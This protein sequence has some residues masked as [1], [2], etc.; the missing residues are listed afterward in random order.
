MPR[1]SLILT[2]SLAGGLTGCLD[3]TGGPST[4]PPDP[5]DPTVDGARGWLRVRTAAGIEEL[6]YVVEGGRAIHQGDIDLGAIDEVL[7]E[8]GGAVNAD[9]LWTNGVVRYWF[10]PEFAPGAC[11]GTDGDADCVCNSAGCEQARDVVREVMEELDDLLPVTISEISGSS[12]SGDYIKVFYESDPDGGWSGKSKV[13]MQGGE[14][15]LRFNTPDYDQAST[16][17]SRGTTRHEVLHAL[18]MWHE[19]ARTDRDG[20]VNVDEGCI[21]SDDLDQYEIQWDSTDVG[22]YDFRSVMHYQAGQFC[23]PWAFPTPDPD[24]DG[25]ICPPMVKWFPTEPDGSDAQTFSSGNLT[26]EDVNTLYHVY[27][28]TAGDNELGDHYGEVLAVGDFNDDGYDDIAVGAPLEDFGAGSTGA[29]Y[30]YRGTSEGPVYWHQITYLSLGIPNQIRTK[31]GAALAVGRFDD[32]DFVDLAVGAPG[33][34]N[35]VGASTASSGAVF[36]MRG[37]RNGL[38]LLRRIDQ[39]SPALFVQAN[40]DKFGAALAAGDLAGQGYDALVIGAPADRNGSNQTSGAIYAY[41]F[42]PDGS[43]VRN[44]TRFD[45]AGNATE[46]GAALAVGNLDGDGN[47]DL[48]VGIPGHGGGTGAV[49]LMAGRTPP[50]TTTPWSPMLTLKTSRVGT[51]TAGRFGASLAIGSLGLNTFHPELAIGAPGASSGRGQVLIHEVAP[52]YAF[53]QIASFTDPTP[54]IG[55]AFGTAL[56]LGHVDAGTASFQDLVIGEPLAGGGKIFFV[57]GG[58]GAL[59]GP[60][61][62]G[63]LG[64]GGDNDAGD[65]FGAAFAIGNVNGWG[66]ISDVDKKLTAERRLD[67]VVG[68]PAETPNILFFPED[69]G[70]GAFYLLLGTSSGLPGYGGIYHQETWAGL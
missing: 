17:P 68:V 41:Q 46:F 13:G 52:N 53:P 56:A 12:P 10:D 31:L 45:F 3:S 11:N 21:L 54:T 35:T 51:A 55:G 24:G 37:G 64:G 16:Q 14:Q 6:P 4:D 44:P 19:Q 50:E 65:G 49:Y 32:D 70:S 29:V 66:K 62:Q 38:S 61:T 23:I 34:I 63:S 40:G 7:H 69:P 30:V 1:S 2:L 20:F 48:A 5:D 47:A 25:C 18:G 60:M 28:K 26:V 9:Q 8:R 59:I 43:G 22:P 58:S 33:L 67:L 27:G 42:T 57:A 36:V 39:T 15:P